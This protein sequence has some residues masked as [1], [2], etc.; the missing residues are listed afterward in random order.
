MLE[1]NN[2]SCEI[3]REIGEA[4][5]VTRSN[6]KRYP[7]FELPYLQASLE[8]LRIENRHRK[9]CPICQA[10]EAAGSSREAA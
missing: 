5:R 3:A 1:T 4:V 9:G 7:R 10:E 2:T 6:A 8:L